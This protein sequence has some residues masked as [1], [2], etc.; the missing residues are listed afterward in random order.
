MSERTLFILFNVGVLAVL[1][2]DLGIFNRKAHAASVKEAATW[3]A[4]WITLSLGFAGVVLVNLGR[5]SALEFV[6]P[7][8]L[9]KAER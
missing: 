3:S 9:E 6:T 4:V 5:Q 1:A 7:W 8:Q 2:I